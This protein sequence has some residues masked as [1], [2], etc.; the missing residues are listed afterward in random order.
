MGLGGS[1]DLFV[2][3]VK[4]VPTWWKKVFKWEGL[5]RQ[6]YDLKNLKRWKRQFKVLPILWKILVGRI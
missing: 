1:F 4:D 2:G 6:F 3:E 5:Y